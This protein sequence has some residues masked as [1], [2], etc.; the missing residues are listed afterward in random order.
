M[1]ESGLLGD[2][3]APKSSNRWEILTLHPRQKDKNIQQLDESGR[4]DSSQKDKTS[5]GRINLDVHNL[6]RSYFPIDWNYP[7]AEAYKTPNSSS[8]WQNPYIQNLCRR[9]KHPTG[10]WISHRRVR[11]QHHRNACVQIIHTEPQVMPRVMHRHAEGS[12][13]IHNP[14]LDFP[15][16]V[17]TR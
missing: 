13:V 14:R 2:F 9:Q 15:K 8:Q 5:T 16:M 7:D 12:K 6:F 4:S 1:G 17:S 3:Q 10:G 11:S